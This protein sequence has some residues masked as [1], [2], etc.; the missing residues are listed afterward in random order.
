MQINFWPNTPYYVIWFF[1]TI[2]IIYFAILFIFNWKKKKKQIESVKSRLKSTEITEEQ[3]RFLTFG[4]ILFVYRFEKI[5]EILP[6]TRLE[7]H[8]FWLANQWW[9]SNPISAKDTIWELLSLKNSER[10]DNILIWNDSEVEKIKKN[11]SKGLKIDISEVEAVKS[12]FAWDLV[13]AVSLSKWCFWCWFLTEDEMWN[14]MERASKIAEEKAENWKDYNVSFL[15]WRTLHWFELYE[16]VNEAEWLL[17]D[18]EIR[19]EKNP[20]KIYKIKN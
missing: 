9:I 14:F 12:T 13:R 18:E 11:I 5:L 6:E 7:M 2:F 15:F 3:K 8:I 10:L 1:A 4:S 17:N 20:Y 16:I 19:K